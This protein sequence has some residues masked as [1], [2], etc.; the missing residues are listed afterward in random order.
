MPALL[1][2]KTHGSLS[3]DHRR[4]QLQMSIRCVPGLRARA[5]ESTAQ[6]QG[7]ERRQHNVPD[8]QQ[9]T[10]TSR[11]RRLRRRRDTRQVGCPPPP[12]FL[13]QHIH[14][15]T[16]PNT[17]AHNVRPK[18]HNRRPPRLHPLPLVPLRPDPRPLS[19]QHRDLRR[20]HH[21]LLHPPPTRPCPRPPRTQP[22][23]APS[24]T[25]TSRTRPRSGAQSTRRRL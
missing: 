17:Q 14:A 1:R 16:Q 13:T 5:H 23:R 19:L 9:S 8:V 18:P 3:A 25:R 20:L 6:L 22:S 10:D 24:T 2:G 4:Q 15:L 11:D 7:V 12:L 21:P